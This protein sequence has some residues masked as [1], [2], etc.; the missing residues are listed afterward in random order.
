MENFPTYLLEVG[1]Q[2]GNGACRFIVGGL[3]ADLRSN[4]SHRQNCT[5]IDM[6]DPYTCRIKAGRVTTLK[7]FLKRLYRMLLAFFSSFHTFGM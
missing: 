7:T 3:T 5:K 2:K 4:W 6:N 1:G